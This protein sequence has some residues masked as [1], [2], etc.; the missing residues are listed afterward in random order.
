[1]KS[2]I[3]PSLFPLVLFLSVQGSAGA[4]PAAPRD[5]AKPI[6]PLSLLASPQDP[7]AYYKVQGQAK[8]LI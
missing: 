4:A 1:M 3:R 7:E 5:D 2:P 8:A 6:W